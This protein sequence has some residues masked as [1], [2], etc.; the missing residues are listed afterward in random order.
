MASAYITSLIKKIGKEKFGIVVIS[1]SGTTLEPAL[2]FRIFRNIL[3]KNVGISKLHKYIVAVT[4]KEKGT[5]HDFAKKYH[6]ATFDIPNN[7]GGRFSTLTSVGMFI[8]ILK[9]LDPLLILKGAQQAVKD[10]N[11]DNIAKNTAFTYACYRHYLNTVKHYQIE[12]FIVYDPA[13]Q[14]VGEM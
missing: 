8:F 14:F 1:K 3:Q 2:S 9:G 11:D 6:I 10:T 5:L 13:L 12:N 4:D 7:I